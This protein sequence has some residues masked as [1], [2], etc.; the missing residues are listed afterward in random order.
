MGTTITVKQ[1]SNY[2]NLSGES[3]I[4]TP[5]K[6]REIPSSEGTVKIYTVNFGGDEFELFEDMVKTREDIINQIF[7]QEAQ[8]LIYRVENI[9]ERLIKQDFTLE[10]IK[11]AFQV[12]I[13]QFIDANFTSSN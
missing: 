3:F 8:D 7:Q 9:T 6:I 13:E 4:L 12:E 1:N 10:E 5:D 2:P 11:N